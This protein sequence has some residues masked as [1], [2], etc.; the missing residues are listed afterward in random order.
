MRKTETRHGLQSQPSRRIF[1]SVTRPSTVLP[2]HS[3]SLTSSFP[4]LPSSS[5]TTCTRAVGGKK[6]RGERGREEG[7]EGKEGGREEG[8]S[9]LV[10]GLR[11]PS[12]ESAS[13]RRLMRRQP[14]EASHVA[15]TGASSFAFLLDASPLNVG[16]VVVVVGWKGIGRASK[17][18]MLGFA[19]PLDT[20]VGLWTS[21]TAITAS[22]AKQTKGY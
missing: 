13:C 18:V 11:Q 2:G 12:S 15:A 7:G 4:G 8:G 22:E 1:F 20:S 10:A 19:F 3:Y 17:M 5:W 21:R 6:E 16:T 14:G 9:R